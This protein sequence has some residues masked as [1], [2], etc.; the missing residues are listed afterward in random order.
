MHKKAAL[1]PKLTVCV[2]VHDAHPQRKLNESSD[3][4]TG[5]YG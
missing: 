4:C 5:P 1:W 3:Q 2:L